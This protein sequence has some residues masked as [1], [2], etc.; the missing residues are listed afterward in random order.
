V[1]CS[2]DSGPIADRKLMKQLTVAPDLL[3][4]GR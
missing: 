1:T 2:A 4:V 3:L